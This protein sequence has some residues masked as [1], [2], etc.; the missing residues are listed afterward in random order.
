MA[1]SRP[2]QIRWNWPIR[3]KLHQGDQKGKTWTRAQQTKVMAL[4]D[5]SLELE[6][7]VT[8]ELGQ[9]LDQEGH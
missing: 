6:F 3:R 5:K 8:A 4:L 9:Q 1:Q 2:W 7:G